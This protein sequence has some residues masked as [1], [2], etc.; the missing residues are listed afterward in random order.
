MTDFCFLSGGL[1]LPCL[2]GRWCLGDLPPVKNAWLPGLDELSREATVYPCCHNS[3]L[4]GWRASCT[5]PWK[6]TFPS[7][8]LVPRDSSRVSFPFAEL[9]VCPFAVINLNPIM[10]VCW[11]LRV[12]PASHQTQ[13]WSRGP[14][15]TYYF[16]SS[17]K[18][19]RNHFLHLNPRAEVSICRWAPCTA[20]LLEEKQYNAL[21]HK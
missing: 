18:D 9:A 12:F 6:G 3:L 19:K 5:T 14:Q 16:A 21:C 4:E 1:K 13:G 17:N 10:T 8:C 11:V 20:L 2:S 7:L 15:N